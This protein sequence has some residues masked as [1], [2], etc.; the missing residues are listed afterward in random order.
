MIINTIVI[1]TFN[2]ANLLREAI[3][4]VNEYTKH[5][6]DIEILIIDNNSSDNTFDIVEELMKSNPSLLYFKEENQGLSYAKNRAI[7]EASGEIIIF[8]DDD[9][10]ID[11]KWIDAILKPFDDM[12]IAVVGGKVLPHKVQIPGWL[13]FK[14]YFLAS[15]FDPGDEM[16][17]VSHVMGG[18][19]AIR[20]E[21]FDQIGVFDTALGRKGS[22]LL[23][24]EENDLYSRITQKGYEIC[25]APEAII[26][27]KIN[28]KLNP[29]YILNYAFFLGR[30]SANYEKNNIVIKFIFK[31][32]KNLVFFPYY[33]I[34]A[35]ICKELVKNCI[36]N[37][38][39]KEYAKGYL[40]F[41]KLHNV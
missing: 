28:S 12:T 4:N 32:L 17:L 36:S 11:E 13:P 20:K 8:L 6:T 41:W 3:I 34:K 37:A 23:S 24:G 1:P 29:E 2:R 16:A 14:Y 26:Y 21:V 22:V 30:S 10:E 15:I 31:Y 18:N 40:S 27:H 9:I 35:V 33:F 39:K 19:C 38:I 25:F 7:Q 5:R